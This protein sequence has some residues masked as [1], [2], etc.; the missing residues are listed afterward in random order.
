MNEYSF[1][2]KDRI[3]QGNTAEIYRLGGGKILKL[4]RGGIAPAAIEREYDNSRIAA[5]RLNEV[6]AVYDILEHDGRMG[7]VFQEASGDDMMRLM[8]SHPLKLRGYIRDFA[9]YHAKIN[10]PVAGDMRAVA[11]KLHDEL[12]WENDLS[13]S[14]KQRIAEYLSRLPD[15]NCLCH[16]DFHP[17]NVM[18]A[19]GQA[20]FLDW[21]TACM[22][23]ACADAARTYL[24]LKYGEP[25]HA[26]RRQRLLICSVMRLTG[27]IYLRRYCRLTGAAKED[28]YRW[29]VP[30]AA[31]RLS[32]WLT[33]HERKRLLRLIHRGMKMRAG[34][35]AV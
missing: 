24:L 22:G 21:M 23:D 17:G 8:L 31:A 4:F 27:R 12:G 20:V 6:P 35:R 10:L 14:E 1:S 13:E 25:L 15:G 32:E 33:E 26:S 9:A 7:I 28:I 3:A 5:Q 11:E 19:D 29:L 34:K 2:E 16:F 18:I 30:V